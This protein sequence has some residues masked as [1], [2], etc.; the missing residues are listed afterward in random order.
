MNTTDKTYEFLYSNYRWP[1]EGVQRLCPFSGEPLQ[2]TKQQKG[3]NGKPWTCPKCV[4]YFSEEE[5]EKWDP[6]KN[7]D[8]PHLKELK[9]KG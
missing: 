6:T 1:E 4:W 7:K 9:E 2:I 3:Y 8:C 5:L